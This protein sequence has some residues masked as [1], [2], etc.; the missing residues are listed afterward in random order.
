MIKTYGLCVTYVKWCGIYV[1][2]RESWNCVARR[3]PVEQDRTR[4]DEVEPRDKTPV[5][6]PRLSSTNSHGVWG[7]WISCMRARE[8]P[9]QGLCIGVRRRNRLF[10]LLFW[11]KLP[12][13][14]GR[15]EAIGYIYIYICMYIYIY[16]HDGRVLSGRFSRRLVEYVCMY[17]G[18]LASASR[19]L[20]FRHQ[21]QTDGLV[22][23][24]QV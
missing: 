24:F 9:R 22:N 3:V 20:S 2:V 7:P 10:F 12:P 23:H 18:F 8:W 21:E 11:R 19:G 6:L 15:A 1:S 14:G 16:I 4:S 5:V 17:L 13:A